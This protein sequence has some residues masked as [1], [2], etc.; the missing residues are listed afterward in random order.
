M[1]KKIIINNL[2]HLI[3]NDYIFLDVPYYTNIGD[4]LIWAGT[5]EFLK[6]I[7][8][9]C[10]YTSNFENYVHQHIEKKHIILLSG[11]GNWGDLYPNHNAFRKKIIEKYSNN[12]I[13]ILPQ[14]IHYNSRE[15]FWDDIDFF[16]KHSNVIICVR[17]QNSYDLLNNNLEN[18]TILLIPDMAFFASIKKKNSKIQHK[19]ILYIKRNDQEL[20]NNESVIIPT[21]AEISDWPSFSKCFLK[22]TIIDIIFGISRRVISV[23]NSNLSKYIKDFKYN[24]F[25]RNFYVNIGTEFIDKYDVVYTTRLHGMILS[26][27][28]EKQVYLIDNSYGKNSN[29]YKTWLSDLDCIHLCI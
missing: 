6:T 13:I 8:H 18:N 19:Q 29:F 14:S 3:D 17:D 7:P 28:L 24:Y 10:L 1:L 20:L 15:A 2:T 22:K 4:H 16:K 27:L 12:R 25:T 11:G 21:E 9:K 26:I 5:I 23:F